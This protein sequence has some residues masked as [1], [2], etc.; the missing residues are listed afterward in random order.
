MICDKRLCGRVVYCDTDSCIYIKDVAYTVPEG[1][2]LGDWEEEHSKKGSYFNQFVGLAPKTY[3]IEER[4][5]GRTLGSKFRAKGF[6]M[7]EA[8]AL[9]LNFDSLYDLYRERLSNP[10][11]EADPKVVQTERM[12][13][14]RQPFFRGMGVTTEKKKLAYKP[15]T[16][17]RRL[18]FR[19]TDILVP[20]GHKGPSADP[21]LFSAQTRIVHALQNLSQ[22]QRDQAPF[23]FRMPDNNLKGANLCVECVKAWLLSCDDH[24]PQPV[25]KGL[26][27][28][29]E[30][31]GCA[32]FFNHQQASPHHFF[33][34]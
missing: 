23:L 7:N 4:R 27:N 26:H 34:S 1:D 2:L 6:V 33:R 5:G 19:K 18:D 29:T 9:V 12:T 17:K 28:F 22:R 24:L 21:Q 32:A 15:S 8:S 11:G 14:K 30:L 10:D 31:K 20:W 25:L 13:M 3:A 16:G